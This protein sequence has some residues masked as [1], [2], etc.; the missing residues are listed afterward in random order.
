MGAL[1]T[2]THKCLAAQ[3]VTS[4][5]IS[6]TEVTGQIGSQI[7]VQKNTSEKKK[8]KTTI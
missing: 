8:K 6:E 5:V 2:P 4:K 7:D 3:V 1:L